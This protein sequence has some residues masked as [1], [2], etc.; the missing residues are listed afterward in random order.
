M[1]NNQS[2][3]KFI[4]FLIFFASFA[5]FIS[6]KVKSVEV[7]KINAKEYTFTESIQQTNEENGEQNT[8]ENIFL[9]IN[10][11][12]NTIER[13]FPTLVLYESDI[14]GVQDCPDP[15]YEYTTERTCERRKTFQFDIIDRNERLQPGTT[16]TIDSY[17][18]LVE[19]EVPPLISGSRPMD[20][21]VRQIESAPDSYDGQDHWTQRPD[22][23]QTNKQVVEGNAYP[24]DG[25]TKGIVARGEAA[26]QKRFSIEYSLSTGGALSGE[27]KNEYVIHQYQENTCGEDCRNEH[28]PTPEKSLLMSYVLARSKNYPVY[29]ESEIAKQQIGQRPEGCDEETIFYNMDIKGNKPIACTLV[30]DKIKITITKDIPDVYEAEACS[31]YEYTITTEDGEE[32]VVTDEVCEETGS[33]VLV[34]ESPWGVE[35]ICEQGEAGPCVI[36]YNEVRN[37]DT[38]IPGQNIKENF[39]VLTDCLIHIDQ[40]KEDIPI[41]CAWDIN[42]LAEELEFQSNDNLPGELYPD[43]DTYIQFQVDEAEIRTDPLFEM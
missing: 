31:T 42:H 38:V 17:I 25:Q 7:D 12:L 28:N 15:F 35:K 2:N 1:P 11:E 21:S 24:G 10:E 27:G 32:E 39:Y 33:V 20:T 22:G 41:K 43:K 4:L 36:E 29:Y 23:E 16:L 19:I 30:P 14:L 8:T 6:T 13:F 3:R 34:M 26:Q 18:E 9:E 37:G 40:I 5:Y